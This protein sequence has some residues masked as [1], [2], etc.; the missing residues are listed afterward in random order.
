VLVRNKNDLN[1]MT[2]DITGNG[3]HEVRIWTFDR[4]LNRTENLL[5]IEGR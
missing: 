2:I 5:T 4:F 1:E 3:E